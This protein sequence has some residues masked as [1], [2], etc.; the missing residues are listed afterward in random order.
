MTRLEANERIINH[1]QNYIRAYPD[2][3]FGQ[4]L[5]NMGIAT[6][7]VDVRRATPEEY[8]DGADKTITHYR[9]IFFEESTDTLNKLDMKIV[10]EEMRPINYT[11]EETAFM[12]G[13]VAATTNM[14]SMF[15]KK[16]PELKEWLNEWSTN[17]EYDECMDAL[18]KWAEVNE[19]I[20]NLRDNGTID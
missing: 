2:M 17:I 20:K 6:H 14:E 9:D 7:M 15:L 16:V 10:L 19:Q 11:P 12:R 13:W 1:I 4:A 3:R 8:A 18:A 5:Y